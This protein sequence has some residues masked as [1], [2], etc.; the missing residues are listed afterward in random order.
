MQAQK[1]DGAQHDV[2]VRNSTVELKGILQ[3]QRAIS[4]EIEVG[5]L[6]E[7]LLM[8]AMDLVSTER[9]LFFLAA[10][11][12]SKSRPKLRLRTAASEWLFLG[13]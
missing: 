1:A 12:S 4:R 8:V 10:G 2:G 6:I 7:T 3:A 11:E 13:H 5:R 9:G